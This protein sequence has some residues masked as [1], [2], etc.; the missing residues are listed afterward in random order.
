MRTPVASF[1]RHVGSS[2]AEKAL[3]IRTLPDVAWIFFIGEGAAVVVELSHRKFPMPGNTSLVA[4]LY[5]VTTA[6]QS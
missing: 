3:T 2:L 5:V 6:N 4:L 1:V